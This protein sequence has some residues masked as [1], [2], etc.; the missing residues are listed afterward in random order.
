[1]RRRVVILGSILLA[2]LSCNIDLGTPGQKG[3]VLGVPYRQQEFFNYCAVAAVQ[4][5]RLYDRRSALTQTQI[6]NWIGR[7]PN[8]IELANAVRY[9]TFSGADAIWDVEYDQLNAATK[10]ISAFNSGVPSIAV[11]RLDHVGV[12][13]GGTWYSTGDG[14]AEWDTVYLHDPNP[15]IGPDSPWT[16]GAWLAL[17]C[18]PSGH[19]CE[20]IVSASAIY[21]WQANRSTWAPHVTMYGDGGGGRQPP[22]M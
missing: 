13:D 10:Q 5:W 19:D 16:P 6:F 12:I 20:Q 8:Q 2:T 1:M 17:S 7:A 4:M 9:F 11:I 15:G 3:D 21:N 22:P 18:G 14:N